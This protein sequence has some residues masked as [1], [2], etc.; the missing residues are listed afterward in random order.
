MIGLRDP[1]LEERL[2]KGGK[3]LSLKEVEKHLTPNLK[4]TFPSKKSHLSLDSA[5]PK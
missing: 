1:K 3:R 2:E 4:Q 5:H